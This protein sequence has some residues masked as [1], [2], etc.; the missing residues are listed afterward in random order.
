MKSCLGSS[1]EW[2]N[3]VNAPVPGLSMVQ[4]SASDVA[5]VLFSLLY[6]ALTTTDGRQPQRSCAR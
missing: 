6:T 5:G 4:A 3:M 1:Y 2:G